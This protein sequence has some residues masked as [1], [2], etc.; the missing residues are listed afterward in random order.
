MIVEGM[1]AILEA[2]GAP[3]AVIGGQA[4]A[5]RGHPG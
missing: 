2:L 1:V 3:Y 4:V 5:L